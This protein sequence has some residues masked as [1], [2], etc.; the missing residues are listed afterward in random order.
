MRFRNN[1]FQFLFLVY[2]LLCVQVFLSCRCNPRVVIFVYVCNVL[3]NDYITKGCSDLS[4]Y[5]W[6]TIKIMNSNPSHISYKEAWQTRTPGHTRN[7]IKCLGRV[8]TPCW[9]FT[10]AIWSGKRSNSQSSHFKKKNGLKMSM[11]HV[12]KKFD[13]MTACI[14]KYNHYNDHETWR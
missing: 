9:P 11:K 8:G 13:L 4:L 14:C 1:F 7:G 12:R 2:N 10:M 5:L 6:K 3:I